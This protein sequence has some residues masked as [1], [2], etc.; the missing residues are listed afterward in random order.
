MFSKIL[1]INGELF[2][3]VLI[4]YHQTTPVLPLGIRE[5]MFTIV[6]FF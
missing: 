5:L 6:V 2:P 1:K 3:L 4:L